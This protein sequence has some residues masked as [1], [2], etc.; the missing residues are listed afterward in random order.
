MERALLRATFMRTKWS[1]CGP[2]FVLVLGCSSDPVE[3]ETEEETKTFTLETGP[4]EVPYG[5]EIQECF[6]F[7][8][9]SDEPVYVNRIDFTQLEGSHHMNLFRVRTIVGLD[10]APGDVVRG[11]GSE[12]W[13]SVN[14]ADWP[15]IANTQNAGDTA[16]E[17]PEGV[18]LRFEPRERI[19]LQSHYVNAITQATPTKGGVT[20]QFSHAAQNHFEHELGTVFATN[21]DVEVCPGQEGV[22]YSESAKVALDHPI[23]IVAANGHFHSRG[24]RFTMNTWDQLDGA[25][26]PFYESNHWDDPP[27]TR[28]LDVQIPTGGGFQWTCQ[29]SAQEDEC[30]DEANGC[31]FTFGGKVEFQEH[32]NAFVYYYPKGDTDIV[33]F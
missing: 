9:P 13:K 3:V 4:I 7:E 1:W 17:L 26:A 28:D 29:F 23:T 24:D 2:V 25:G 21:Q 5:S 20:V 10:G 33:R 15:L 11:E 22:T 18:A 16:W 30:G 8:I 12:C 32:C 6:F 27:F 19:M 14:W 31:C